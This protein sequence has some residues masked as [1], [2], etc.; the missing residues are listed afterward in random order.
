MK[1]ERAGEVERLLSSCRCT[2]KSTKVW[3]NVCFV[4]TSLQLER[5]NAHTFPPQSLRSRQGLQAQCWSI[6]CNCTFEYIGCF[7]MNNL[8]HF[9]TQLFWVAWLNR[10]KFVQVFFSCQKK[11]E[12][13]RKNR[14]IR[15][16]QQWHAANYAHCLNDLMTLTLSENLFFLFREL[17]K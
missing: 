14:D 17:K 16:M 5:L 8:S 13:S 15:L 6:K 4:S 7:I 9:D 10:L 3:S 2:I 12:H 11:E 1:G